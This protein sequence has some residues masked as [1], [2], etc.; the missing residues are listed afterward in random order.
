MVQ[1][2]LNPPDADFLFRNGSFQQN[3][4]HV[5]PSSA[6][7]EFML[8]TYLTNVDPF[9]RIVHKP[10]LL[11]GFNH[12]RRGTLGNS[13]KREF[14]AFI[15]AIYALSLLSLKDE[16]VLSRVGEDRRTL[17]ARYKSYVEDGLSSCAVTTT[18]SLSTLRLFLMYICILFWTGQML[19][20]SSL[21]GL[22]FR[23]AQRMGFHHDPANFK[24][25]PWSTEIRRRM[26]HFLIHLDTHSMENHGL[27]SVFP[28]FDQTGVQLPQNTDDE[29]WDLSEFASFPPAAE[30]DQFTDM[31]FFLMQSELL[32][33]TRNVLTSPKYLQ[34]QEETYLQQQSQ[35]LKPVRQRIEQTFLRRLD[36]SKPIQRLVRD[37]AEL[38][39][40][41]VALMQVQPVMLS[42]NEQTKTTV[43]LK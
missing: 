21:L 39:L 18:H 35:M 6:A 28:T 3:Q 8:E 12:F 10:M 25:S 24:L 33:L 20:A 41:N 19:H 14:E 1:N 40:M 29:A 16:V 4:D 2:E 27:E 11:A 23:I 42:A 31:T 13:S 43:G 7:S 15:F 36:P 26:W 30:L 9:M 17:L 37:M 38:C 22:A 32:K 34:A 5:F